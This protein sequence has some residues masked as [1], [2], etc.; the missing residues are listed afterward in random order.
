MRSRLVKTFNATKFTKKVLGF[1]CTK[2]IAL[3]I[4]YFANQGEYFFFLGPIFERTIFEFMMQALVNEIGMLMFASFLFH[5]QI[6]F[7][8]I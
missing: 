2:L 3:N 7:L 5:V 8:S 1:F 6:P 4:F